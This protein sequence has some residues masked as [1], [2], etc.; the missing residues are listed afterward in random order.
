MFPIHPR[1]SDFL[2]KRT[3]SS[4]SW[5]PETKPHGESEKNIAVNV[6]FFG[7]DD[8]DDADDDDDDDDD[9]DADDK[10]YLSK[11][12]ETPKPITYPIKNGWK[13]VRTTPDFV[14]THPR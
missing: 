10:P 11:N 2:R 6:S 7:G 5:S 4:S 1:T 13:L 3:R 9:D 12:G 14:A 8:D